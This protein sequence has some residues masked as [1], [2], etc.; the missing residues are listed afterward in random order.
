MMKSFY[1]YPSFFGRI[2]DEVSFLPSNHTLRINAPKPRISAVSQNC[3]RMNTT[4]RME[5]MKEKK[6][7][8]RNIPIPIMLLKSASPAVVVSGCECSITF[9]V[10]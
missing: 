2:L 10:R 3:V 4:G 1:T 8:E 6:N 9:V 5:L 7:G